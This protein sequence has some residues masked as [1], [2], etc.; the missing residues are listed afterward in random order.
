MIHLCTLPVYEQVYYS[1]GPPPTPAVVLQVQTNVFSRWLTPRVIPWPW[2]GARDKIDTCWL[3]NLRVNSLSTVIA[4]MP[5]YYVLQLTRIH[6]CIYKT[7]CTLEPK[8]KFVVRRTD[9]CMT[10]IFENEHSITTYTNT[11]TTTLLLTIQYIR[12]LYY[13]QSYYDMLTVA[14][15]RRQTVWIEVECGMF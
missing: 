7:R 13:L 9:G 11:N 6:M 1:A 10:S 3:L 8:K 4:H 2:I 15:V 12:L 5:L 14:A